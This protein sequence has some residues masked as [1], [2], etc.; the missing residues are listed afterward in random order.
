LFLYRTLHLSERLQQGIH[1]VAGLGAWGPVVFIVLYVLATVCL[2]PASALTLGAGLVFGVVWGTVYVSVGSTLG[3]A[4]AFLIA[5]YLLQQR[6]ERRLSAHPRF[7][8]IASAVSESGWK[9]VFLTRLSPF[10]PFNLLNYG[11]GLTRVSF[12][13]YLLASWIGMLPGTLMYVYLGSLAQEALQAKS[14]G[15]AQWALYMG[16][17]IA[18][19]LATAMISFAAKRAL[20]K[21]L[22]KAG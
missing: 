13:G 6:L 12:R 2:A 14:V 10:L 4:A 21:H 1:W 8:A 20:E 16:G 15:A 19:I 11:Y 22:Q 18:T 7:A 9:I 5:R 3:A 17:L